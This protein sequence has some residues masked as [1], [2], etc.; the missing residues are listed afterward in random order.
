MPFVP[1]KLRPGVNVEATPTLNEAGISSCNLIR[2][3]SGLPQKFGGWLKFFANVLSGVPRGLHA[4]K[5]LSGTTRL[6][7]GTTTS[8]VT[9]ASGTLTDITP[10][11]KTTNP[12]LNFSTTNG[13][14]TVTIVDAGI[15]NVTTF[16]AIFLNTPISVGGLILHGIYAITSIVGA[17]SYQITAISNAT[18]TVANAGQVPSFATTA[19]SSIVTVTLNS[20]GLALSNDFTFPIATTVD[21]ITISGTYAVQSVPS[22]NTFTI[23]VN[24]QASS[25]TSASMNSGAAQILYYINLGPPAPGAG[26][27]LGDY[28]AGGFGTGVVPSAQT[29]TAITSTNWSHDNWGSILLSCPRNGGVYYWEPNSG[30]TNAFLVP[31]APTFNGGIFVAMPQRILVCWGST[32]AA[33]RASGFTASPEERDPLMVRWSDVEDFSVFTV[34][35]TTQAG[36]FRIPTGSEII[37]AMQGP[38]QALLWTDIDVYAMQYLGPPLVFGFN[39]ISSGCGLIGQHAAASMRGIVAWM[40]LGSFF[41]LTNRGV[42]EIP[43][44][45]WDAVFQDLDTANLAKITAAADSQFS[46]FIWFYPSLSGGTGEPDKYVKV[47]LSENFAWDYGTLSR[48]AWIDQSVLGQ[49]IGASPSGIIYQH[50]TGNDA[51]TLPM[52]SFFETGWF[53]IAEGEEFTFVDLFLPDMKWGLFNGAQ[54]GTVIVTIYAADTPNGTVRTYGPFTM[55]AASTF[56]NCRLRGRQVK[57]RFSSSDFGS[58]WRLGNMRYRARADGRR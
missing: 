26:Y 43:C 36:G 39:K 57:I 6:A 18:A 42:Q 37:G 31:T 22:A 35:S 9:I 47:N 41:M 25:T 58:F 45:V 27:G 21:G 23:A 15:S 44:P 5:D 19:N 14:A 3:K 34:T 10:Q 46:E 4:W 2:F 49:P 29:G 13:S 1:L 30:H 7:A 20:H 16:D 50:E 40:G 54:T 48:S 53:T 24:T 11:T 51:D 8:L 12:T 52:A 56:I 38:Q 55:T 32:S 28:G 33:P 17:T